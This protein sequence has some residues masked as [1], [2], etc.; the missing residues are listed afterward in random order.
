MGFTARSP[1]ATVPFWI[2]PP[3]LRLRLA[4]MAIPRQHRNNAGRTKP[5]VIGVAVLLL[6]LLSGCTLMSTDRQISYGLAHFKMGLNGQAIPP[7]VSAAAAL[8]RENPADPRLVDVLIALGTMAMSEK[9]YDFADNYFAGALK[10]AEG[11]QPPDPVRLRNALVNLGMYSLTRQRLQEAVP[12][13]TRACTL[14]E[15]FEKREFHAIDL[16]NLASAYQSLKQIGRA[17]EL[18][19]TALRV[20]NDVTDESMLARTKGTILH[21]LAAT[22]EELGQDAEA[23]QTFKSALAVLISGGTSVEP[24]R[25]ETA[26]RSWAKFLRKKGREKEAQAIEARAVEPVAR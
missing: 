2:S 24:W 1:G 4:M 19:S 6:V 23:E 26:R 7:L 21:N 22:Y 12:L 5:G 25:V 17:N 15:K 13:L 3:I 8:E 16:D 11:L 9:R 18:Q 20:V 10:A 14:S